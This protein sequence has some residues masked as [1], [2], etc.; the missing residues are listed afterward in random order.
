M[1]VYWFFIRIY[2]NILRE[3]LQKVRLQFFLEFQ[4]FN[5]IFQREWLSR[6]A[7]E[8]LDAISLIFPDILSRIQKIEKLEKSIGDAS[9]FNG[10]DYIASLH[11]DVY[12]ILSQVQKNLEIQYQSLMEGRN[13]LEKIQWDETIHLRKAIHQTLEWDIQIALEKV[14]KN[15]L[16]LQ[17]TYREYNADTYISI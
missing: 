9:T 5:R 15:I 11:H 10:N 2:S 13:S 3:K 7:G 8:H 1:M 16:L 17:D 14:N 6:N 4:E 12:H